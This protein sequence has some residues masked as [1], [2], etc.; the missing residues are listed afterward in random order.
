[1]RSNLP[2]TCE[3]VGG[4]DPRLLQAAFVAR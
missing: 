2:I 1:M 3:T 4:F